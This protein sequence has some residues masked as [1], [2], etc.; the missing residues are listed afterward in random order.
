MASVTDCFEELAFLT[1]SSTRA[2]LLQMVA[3]D[4]PLQHHE[5][6]RRFECDRTT[7]QRNITALTEHGWV[8][9]TNDTYRI[10]EPG[11]LLAAGLGDCVAT[12]RTALELQPI[13]RWTP[14]DAFDF[15]TE[16]LADAEVAVADGADPDR[17]VT[18]HL[19]VLRT[20][21]RFRGFIPAIGRHA[22]EVV[23]RRV[24]NNDGDF[25]VVMPRPS[26]ERL[27]PDSKYAA[28][29][30]DLVASDR[31]DIRVFDGEIP[32]YLGLFE[33]VVQIGV[34]DDEGMRRA[35][36][37]TERDEVRRWAEDAYREYERRA[38]VLDHDSGIGRAVV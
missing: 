35:L 28:M 2:R 8:T 15:D 22:L 12:T 30:A 29:F 14:D 24:T 33:D 1:R 3:Q 32:Y 4:G 11:A 9:R 27:E 25:A 34:K 36:L 37:E 6:R 16:L 20:A 38:A 18:K 23:W 31:I 13:L 5:L 17:A 10:T 21:A 26:L 19:E 7:L